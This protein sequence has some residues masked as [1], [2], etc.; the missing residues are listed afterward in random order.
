MINE[1]RLRLVGIDDHPVEQPD[2]LAPFCFAD[3]VQK[4]RARLPENAVDPIQLALGALDDVSRRMESLARD[5]NV[6]GHF[7]EPDDT[8]RPRAA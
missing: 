1:P 7:E 8:D 4:F 2:P 6:F 3:Y 5:L